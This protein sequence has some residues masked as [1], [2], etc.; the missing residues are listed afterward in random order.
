[1]ASRKHQ[2]KKKYG[3]T[4]EEYEAIIAR[5]CAICKSH[6]KIVLD[7][8]HTSG[9]VRD[10]L[11]NSCNNGLGRFKDNPQ[12]LRKAATYVEEHQ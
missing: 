6:E 7:H 4:V 1:M 9:K 8:C 10:A 5:G 12:F 3:L 11:C 2:I